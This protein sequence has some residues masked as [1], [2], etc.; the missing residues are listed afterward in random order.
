VKENQLNNFFSTSYLAYDIL[1]LGFLL[2]LTGG[3]TNP[4][5]FLIVVPS[6]FSSKYLNLISTIFLVLLSGIV[7]IIV[8][9]Y[10]MEL[11]YPKDAHFHVPEY[12][13]KS[14]PISVFIGL[15]FLVYFG[16]KFG[17][18]H[19]IRKE[20]L[21]KMQSIIA[22]EHELVSLGGQAAA[23]AHSLGTPLSTISLIA[24]DLQEEL[25]N[26]N[27]YKDD[28]NLLISQSH[29]CNEILKKLSLNPSSKE[30][31][32]FF[33]ER[34]ILEYLQEI[35][36][37][38][39]EISDKVFELDYSNN[40]NPIKI[41]RSIEII[42][43]LRNFIGNAN[44]FSK[45][46]INIQISSNE[47]NTDILIKD[48]GEGFSQD[49]ISILGEPYIRS[50]NKNQNTKS[51]MGLGIFIGKTLLEKNYA[52]VKFKNSKSNTGAI[53]EIGWS[54]SNLKEI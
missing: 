32:N 42:F 40:K 28:V 41:K 19:R 2:F 11:P 48:D 35:I 50:S 36:S 24:K 52:N 26:D 33:S 4:F 45:E 34:S 21:D 6:V 27:K 10:Y 8:S 14:I 15:L 20:A 3:I 46:K 53:V 22:K 9:F 30:D 16:V 18:E 13:L 25:G 39:E 1:Q 5:I 43:G 38:F 54:N 49:I 12:Y 37:S 7:L 31:N 51:G 44:K 17:S 29:R 47:Q 23:S